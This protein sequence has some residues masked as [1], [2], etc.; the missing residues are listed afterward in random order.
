M[1]VKI[2]MV[3]LGNICRSPMA[4]GLMRSKIE[5]YGLD[6]V[7]DSAGFEKFHTGDSP[8]YRAVKAMKLHG[9]DISDQ[10]ARPFRSP[11][12]EIFDY[13]YVMDH[14]NYADVRSAAT[15]KAQMQ[16]VDFILNT[17]EPGS[18]KPIPDPYYGGGEGFERVYRML[19]AATEAIA[20]K[21]KNS[22]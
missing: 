16:K 11:D 12:F 2:L 3:C 5:K 10:V 14:N 6:A 8:D 7:V 4:E 13:I 9:I 18:N 20:L 17:L 22:K 21:L 19:D 15:D 1:P